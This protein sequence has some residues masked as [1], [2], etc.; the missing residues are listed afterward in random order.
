MTQPDFEQHMMNQ[1][2]RCTRISLYIALASMALWGVIAGVGALMASGR[3]E[4]GRGILAVP[5]L[6]VVLALAALGF[7]HKAGHHARVTRYP[8]LYRKRR[9]GALAMS[10]LSI[11]LAV[12]VFVLPLFASV[13]TG[14][15]VSCQ[16]N[17]KQLGLVVKMYANESENEVFPAIS[18]EPGRLSFSL[19]PEPGMRPVYP[20]YLDDPLLMVCP[21][22][23]AALTEL[24]ALGAPRAYIDDHSYFYLSHLVTSDEEMAAYAAAYTHAIRHD[25][26]ALHDDLKVAPGSGNAGSDILYRLREGIERFV[27]PD[28]IGPGSSVHTPSAVPVMVERR[29]NH[30]VPG[31]NVLY[32]DGRVEFRKYPGEWPMTPTTMHLLEALDGLDAGPRED[33][34][35]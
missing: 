28:M 17:L 34:E 27:I 12:A 19:E 20:E 21:R 8:G 15:R 33:S 35:K 1:T 18:T 3:F 11:V 16:N 4:P 25:P 24:A 26:A 30:E 9:L 14:R 7:G 32:L 2:A 31:G 22:D 10:Y 29:G 23:K 5:A 13:R 6:A